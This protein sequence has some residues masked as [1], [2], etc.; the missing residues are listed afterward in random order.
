MPHDYNPRN[1]LERLLLINKQKEERRTHLVGLHAAAAQKNIDLFDATLNVIKLTPSL[2]DD[3]E[4]LIG[5][6][7]RH[8]EYLDRVNSDL[9]QSYYSSGSSG[10][11]TAFD[12]TIFL[13]PNNVIPFVSPQNKDEAIRSLE[14][15][16]DVT[17]KF[18]QYEEVL[19]LMKNLGL[20]NFVPDKKN[21]VDQFITAWA[22]Y[23]KPVTPDDPVNTSLIPMRECI[24]T[25]I[26]DLIRRRPKQEEVGKSPDGNRWYAKIISI[27]NQLRRDA[28]TD[29]HVKD[30]AR[31][32]AQD[33]EPRLS[34]A[35][36][37]SLNRSD[38][39]LLLKSCTLFIHEF[40]LSLDSSKLRK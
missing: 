24:E 14:I 20:S 25:M 13:A 38:W 35:K 39:R 4:P 12:V 31:K 37:K 40:L 29:D 1:E 2:H 30:L 15:L 16:D 10:S 21:S 36:T 34:G 8:S 18:A 27:S 32:W 7:K 3:P 23:E 22:A 9:E 33:I 17:E 19:D 26:E 6:L 28:I 11:A 5:S